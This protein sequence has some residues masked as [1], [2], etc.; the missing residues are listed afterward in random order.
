MPTI[1]RKPEWLRIKK[2]EGQNMGY[3]NDLLKKFSLN[4]VC[5]AANCPNRVECYSKK[6]ATFM[7][8]GKECSRNCRFCNVTHKKLEPLDPKEP[9]NV[10]K[11]TVDLGLKHV[12]ITSVTRDD[13]P[14][15]G[16]S[17]FAETIKA[18]RRIKKDI[19]IEVLIPDLL[20]DIDALKIVVD[21]KPEILNHN[22]ETVPRLYPDVRPMAIY[23]RSLDV[24]KNVKVLDP[25]VLTKSGIMVGLGEKEDEVIEVFKDLRQVDC[26]FLTVGQYLQPSEKHYQLKEYVTPE[27]FEMYKEEATKLGFKF[28]ASSPL[29]RSSYKAADMFASK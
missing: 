15:G 19:I 28:V 6:T 4:T 8:L 27:T 24:L 5:E 21:A 12:V 9:E 25:T 7:I 17:H 11:A 18:I 3:V 10:A 22:I 29:V 26:D 14:D 1:K 2:R 23:Q 13:L 20:G 16:A